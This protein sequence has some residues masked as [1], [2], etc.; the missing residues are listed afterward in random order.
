MAIYISRY[1]KFSLA[2]DKRR[3]TFTNHGVSSVFQTENAEE[4]AW[5]E[6]M[7]NYKRDFARTDLLPAQNQSNVISGVRGSINITD[8]ELEK[9][10]TE[11]RKEA[12]KDIEELLKLAL[13]NISTHGKPRRDANNKAV[14]RINELKQKYFCSK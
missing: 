5:L 12:G 7:P 10:K 8:A 9:M 1:K 11:I 13:Q 4:I 14:Q 6:S 2:D 3:I